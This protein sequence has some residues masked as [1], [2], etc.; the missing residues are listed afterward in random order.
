MPSEDSIASR[1]YKDAGVDI[2]RGHA[3]IEAIKPLARTTDRPGVI[4]GPGGFAAVFDPKAAGFRDPIL[5]SA[6]DGVGTKLKIAQATGRH[7]TIGI[8]LVAMCVNDLAVTGAE[9]LF[10]LDYFATGRLEPEV[11]RTVVAGIAEGC[12]QAGCA[13][14]GGETAE[15]PSMYRDGE[16]DLAGFAVGAVERDRWLDGERV[17]PGDVVFGLAASGLHSNGF[18]LVRRVVE[19]LALDYRAPAPFAPGATLGD[20]L[21]TPTRVYVA[22]VRAAL[23]FGIKALAHVTG[24]G[25]VENLPRVLPA[26][27]GAEI[28]AWPLPSVFRWLAQAGGVAPGELARTFNCGVGMVAIAAEAD[29][30][31]VTDAL[32]QAG[33]TVQRIGRIVARAPGQPAVLLHGAETTWA[34]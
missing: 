16:Y 2:D 9:P 27:L 11:A 17:S 18:S 3:L 14:V 4:D 21:L 31:R 10:F 32:S 19:E 1:T 6:T 5:V 12:R 23:P 15:M 33:E 8:D 24:G 7:D 26:G 22:A 29:A 25:I 28:R 30:A 34:G 13:L 20:A